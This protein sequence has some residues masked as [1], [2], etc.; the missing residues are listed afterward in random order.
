MALALLVLLGA[1]GLGHAQSG[2]RKTNPWQGLRILPEGAEVSY[3]ITLSE[4]QWRERLTDFQYYVLREKGTERAFTGKLNKVYEE[5]TYYS[6]ATGQ[7]L[8]SSK[9]KFDSGTGW[10][11]FYEPISPDAVVLIEDKSLFSM[12]VEVVDSS[13]GSHL[14][15][16]FDDGPAPTGLR[17]CMNSASLIFVPEGAEPPH[18][19]KDYLAAYGQ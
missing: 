13:S 16:V 18:I 14:G 3:P 11:S 19:V 10:P 8:F 2:L 12:R 4:E 5:G 17:Y 7:P 1:A 15:H 9:A 6:A